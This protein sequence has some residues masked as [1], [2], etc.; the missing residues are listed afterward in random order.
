MY[1][2]TEGKDWF[3]L[4]DFDLGVKVTKDGLP[5]GPSARHR[6]GTLPFMAYELVG[7]LKSPIDPQNEAKP[8]V[9]QHCIRHDF[10]SLFWVSLWCATR[11]V[12]PTLS[13]SAPTSTVREDWLTEFEKGDPRTIARFKKDFLTSESDMDTAPLSP[14]F[15]HLRSWLDAFRVPF[16]RHRHAA[17]EER[18]AKNQRKSR[19]AHQTPADAL[20]K[21][22]LY[23]TGYGHVTREVLLKAFEIDEEEDQPELSENDDCV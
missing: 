23:E 20:N 12:D 22:R 19:K 2:Q 7:S 13:K 4:I 15:K 9:V 21:F 6:T 17:D 16:W 11:L 8:Q 5:L 3:I 18:L 1:T 10:E 14:S